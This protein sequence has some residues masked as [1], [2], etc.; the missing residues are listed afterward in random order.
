MLQLLHWMPGGIQGRTVYSGPT[1]CYQ[2]AV[3]EI[4]GV[5]QG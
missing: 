5:Q 2:V 1:A 3:G 4:L